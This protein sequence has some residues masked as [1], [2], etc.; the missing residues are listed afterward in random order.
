MKLIDFL[1][2][3]DHYH[4]KLTIYA[5][6]NPAWQSDSEIILVH[7]PDGRTLPLTRDGVEFDY[8]L[9]VYL[10]KD[11]MR[12]WKQWHGDKTPSPEEMCAAVIYYAENDAYMD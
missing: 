3:I 1:P 6:K 11:V 2:D 7:D 8:F 9:E 5:S 4:R 10:A 12:V